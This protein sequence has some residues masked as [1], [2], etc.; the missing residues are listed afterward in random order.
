MDCCSHALPVEVN[1]GFEVECYHNFRLSII[2]SSPE[3]RP[4]FYSRFVNLTLQSY[5]G[6]PFPIIRFED[7][8]DVYSGV[9][10]E[11]PC[12]SAED[13]VVN[14][15]KAFLK[16]G[17][18]MIL[19]LNWKHVP[20]SSFY[21]GQDMIHEALVYGYDDRSRELQM[22]AFEAGGRG[23][24]RIALSYSK[25][26]ELFGRL[27]E[28]NWEKHRWFA[29]YGFPSSSVKVAEAYPGFDSRSLYFALER[30]KAAAGSNQM[31]ATGAAVNRLMADYFRDRQADGGM[32]EEACQVWDTMSGKTILHKKLM[33][34]RLAYLQRGG[35]GKRLWPAMELYRKSYQE[36]L[37]MNWAS[38]R[39][40]KRPDPKDLKTIADGYDSLYTMEK[41]ANL[42]I[43][44][45]LVHR[46]LS[47]FER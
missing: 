19:Y 43:M 31:K 5:E 3:L 6:E 26:R 40:R 32:N 33:L 2:L 14:N 11:S 37:H 21:G 44:E 18:Y 23:Y 34:Q 29:Y 12:M 46:Q 25:C 20:S 10:D 22:L 7:H 24:G 17:R 27:R 42:L 28:E 39:Y 41:R 30:S 47:H 35:D 16:S 1:P 13:D 36:A 9:L 4:W 38:R 8:L 15:I 45:F